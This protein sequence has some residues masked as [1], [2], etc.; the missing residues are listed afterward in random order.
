MY[1]KYTSIKAEGGREVGNERKWEGRNSD[2][3]RLTWKGN[4][5]QGCGVFFVL[6]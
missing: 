2:Q 5:S 6:F 1:V 3:K 4:S